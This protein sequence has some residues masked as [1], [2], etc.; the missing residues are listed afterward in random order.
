MGDTAFMTK[1]TIEM[2]TGIMSQC[3][4]EYQKRGSKFMNELDFVLADTLTC[5]FANFAAVWLSCPTVAVKATKAG[6]AK[7]GGALQVGCSFFVKMSIVFFGVCFESWLPFSSVQSSY[8]IPFIHRA[9]RTQWSEG[10]LRV[11]PSFTCHT[12]VHEG[13]CSNLKSS[14]LS[15]PV[16][17]LTQ[18]FEV[19]FARNL[20]H[21]RHPTPLSV[22]PFI[23][24][25]L[26]AHHCSNFWLPVQ[27]THSKKLQ[28]RE[29]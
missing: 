17:R 29:E 21:S 9:E 7:A 8:M 10:Q 16:S 22:G 4:A 27:P 12:P 25:L 26:R 6:A 2:V 15:M 28:P 1:L 13:P 3:L 14:T 23:F 5:L 11:A 20:E 18:P 24:L 19:Q